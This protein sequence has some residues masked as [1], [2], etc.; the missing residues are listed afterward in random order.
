MSAGSEGE[1]YLRTLQVAGLAP[2]TH[3]SIRPF[4][5]SAIARIAPRDSLH[6]WSAEYHS[7]LE[8]RLWVRPVAPELGAIF[9]STFPYGMNDG[10][11]WAG[12]GFTVTASAGVEG[13]IGPLDFV[14]APQFFRA[15][16]AAF[17]LAPTGYGGPLAFADPQR[18]TTIDLPQRFGDAA[19]QRLDAGQSSVSLNLFRLTVGAS[20]ANEVWGP[21]VESPFLL[22]NNAAGFAHLFAGTDG[23]IS[24]GPVTFGVRVIAGRLDQSDYSSTLYAGRRRSLAGIVATVGI[25]Q[26]PGLEVGAGRLFENVYPDSGAGLRDILRPL[27]ENFLKVNVAEQQSPGSSR[28]TENQIASAFA[29]WLLPDAG[30]ELYGELGREDHSY[31]TRDLI[32]EPDHDFSYMVGLQRVWRRSGGDLLAVRGELLNTEISH[33]NLVRAQTPP[34]VHTPITQGHTQLGQLLGAPGGF[35]GGTTVVAVDWVN[36][37]GRRS[38]TWRRVMREPILNTTDPRDVIQAVTADWVIF[39]PRIDLKPEATAVYNVNRAGSSSVL[40]LRLALSGF[41]H[42]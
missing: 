22:G 4:S 9:N 25:R 33:L 31:D 38:I 3:W 34:Y 14:I 17:P 19:Y 20:T 27:F 8:S 23:P 24:A 5:S 41:V 26:L 35:G 37:G 12:R 28:S 16:N 6:P 13:A 10:P 40:N 7:H 39:R 32:L 11:V 15:Q 2:A 29:R 21:A 30:V 36:A 42:W 18:P 1:R